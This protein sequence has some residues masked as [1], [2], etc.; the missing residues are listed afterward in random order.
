[1][2]CLNSWRVCRICYCYFPCLI[3]YFPCFCFCYWFEMGR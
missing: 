3:L 2:E 1:M